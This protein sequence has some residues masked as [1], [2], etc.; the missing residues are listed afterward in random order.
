MLPSP[1]VF[2]QVLKYDICTYI[3]SY[4][5][6]SSYTFPYIAA[7]TKA[8][9]H[10]ASQRIQHCLNIDPNCVLINKILYVSSSKC[11]ALC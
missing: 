3:P 2:K 9:C 1:T 11:F 6:F 4:D 5:E 10:S 8:D 7:S